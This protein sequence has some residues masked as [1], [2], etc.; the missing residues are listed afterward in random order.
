MYVARQRGVRLALLHSNTLGKL[1]KNSDSC[2]VHIRIQICGVIRESDVILRYKHR[3]GAQLFLTELARMFS[4]AAYMSEKDVLRQRLRT[5]G[6]SD[7]LIE[8]VVERPEGGWTRET[9]FNHLMKVIKPRG[10]QEGDVHEG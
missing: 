1:L 5:I 10:D 9:L 4:V 7:H 3:C 2:E 8:L 6:M